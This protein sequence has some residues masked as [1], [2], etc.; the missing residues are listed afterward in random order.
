[1][2][3]LLVFRG[4]LCPEI[5]K[6]YPLDCPYLLL[7]KH[8]PFHM[9]QPSHASHTWQVG[10]TDLTLMI[11]GYIWLVESCYTDTPTG[12]QKQ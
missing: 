4:Q 8:L 7:H 2:E 6:I 11:K 12:G 5:A 10:E 3:Y 9:L 1:M